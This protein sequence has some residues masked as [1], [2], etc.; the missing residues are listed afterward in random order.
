MAR[1]F[2]TI[3]RDSHDGAL[4]AVGEADPARCGSVKAAYRWTRSFTRRWAGHDIQTT[5]R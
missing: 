4:L 2:V 3:V 1:I 5:R